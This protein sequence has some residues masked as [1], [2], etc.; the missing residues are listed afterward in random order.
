MTGDPD[1]TPRLARKRRSVMAPSLIRH[2]R[3]RA[4]K[5]GEAPGRRLDGARPFQG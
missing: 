5:R 2:P 3:M 1:R 4:W